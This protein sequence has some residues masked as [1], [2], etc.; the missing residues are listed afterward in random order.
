MS[1]NSLS[2]MIVSVAQQLSGKL[3]I[4]FVVI[5]AAVIGLWLGALFLF[6]VLL[7]SQRVASHSRETE[8]EQLHR[9]L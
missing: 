7:Y 6:S 3:V 4:L 1:V 9:R 2:V 5:A 8:R